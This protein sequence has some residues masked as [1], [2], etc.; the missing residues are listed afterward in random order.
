MSPPSGTV[1][2]A[3]RTSCA[4]IG[5]DWEWVTGATGAAATAVMLA[6][7]IPVAATPACRQVGIRMEPPRIGGDIHRT[8]C[9]RDGFNPGA[10]LPRLATRRGAGPHIR[11]RLLSS[12]H[13]P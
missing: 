1:A 5:A 10:P 9:G 7:A 11:S 4:T 12:Q 2:A 13:P 6:T 3:N 8:D